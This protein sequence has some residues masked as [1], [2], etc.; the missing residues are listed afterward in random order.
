MAKRMMPVQAFNIKT[1]ETFVLRTM[2]EIRDRGFN[3]D[4]VGKVARG[5]LLHHKGWTFTRIVEAD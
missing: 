5:D 1:H 4:T 3:P 2:R